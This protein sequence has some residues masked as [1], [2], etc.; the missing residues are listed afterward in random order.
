ML[1]E[2]V[3]SRTTEAAIRMTY[4]FAAVGKKIGEDPRKERIWW[5]TQ[6]I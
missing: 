2:Y 1:K 6:P 3:Q 4:A 5:V